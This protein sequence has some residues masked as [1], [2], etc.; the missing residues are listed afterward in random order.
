M[1]ERVNESELTMTL[2][3]QSTISFK[4][5]EHPD[6]LYGEDVVSAVIDE[7]SRCREEAWHAIRSTLTATNGSCRM[8][9]NVRGRKNWFY[10][11]SRR[12]ESGLEG[13][14][15][16]KITAEDAIAGGVLKRSEIDEAKEVLPLAVYQ[17]LYEAQ[18]SDNN[19]NP[20]GEAAIRAC[21]GA[22]STDAPFV[23]GVDLAK[24]QDWTVIIG[25][26]SSNRVCFF[27]RF[28]MPWVEQ[29][30]KL[31]EIIGST[32]CIIDSTG[33]GD[34]ITE[35]LQRVLPRVEGFKFSSS[36]KQQLMEL[37][38]TKI[39]TKQ[40]TYPDGDIVRELEQFEYEYGRTGVKYSAPPQMHD[41]CVMAL[42][43]ALKGQ[44][45]VPGLGV[46]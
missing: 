10:R 19:S 33:V 46:W 7:A 32:D 20:F 34:P 16:A 45:N 14:Q 21:V 22:M 27:E 25:L 5:G 3:N 39:S 18:A 6:A 40:V 36:S 4:T 35:D 44:N 24:S 42:A 23:Y 28:Q 26:D 2:V 1:L 12:A 38:S 9:G 15:Y 17:E 31:I 29:R 37:L 13:F 41:D 30:K 43:L 8:I 11:L